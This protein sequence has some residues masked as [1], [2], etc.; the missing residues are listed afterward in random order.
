[1]EKRPRKVYV[2]GH[3]IR[4]DFLPNVAVE[5]RPA[6]GAYDHTRQL[7]LLDYTSHEQVLRSALLHEIQH[8]MVQCLNLQSSGTDAEEREEAFV[9]MQQKAWY[10]LLADDRN[11]PV[12]RYIAGL[13]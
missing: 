5:G 8:A 13:K 6:Y 7:I 3:Q 12:I 2:G 1:M 4:I 10:S 9:S 11:A